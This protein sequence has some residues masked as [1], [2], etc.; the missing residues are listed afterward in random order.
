V[1]YGAQLTELAAVGARS[2]MQAAYVD[3]LLDK[4]GLAHAADTLVCHCYSTAYF[5][6]VSSYKLQLQP[7]AESCS[8]T[9][10]NFFSFTCAH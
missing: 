5:G 3:K 4:L 1:L 10:F 7:F 2:V 6:L 8:Y 9:G